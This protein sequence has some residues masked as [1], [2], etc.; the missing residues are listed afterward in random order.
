LRRGHREPRRGRWTPAEWKG[1]SLQGSPFW[2]KE[3]L[4]KRGN[5]DADLYDAP[6]DRVLQWIEGMAEYAAAEFRQQRENK[7]KAYP[8][9]QK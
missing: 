2:L 9:S 4:Q 8:Q 3:Q 1:R 6:Y 7:A 5:Q